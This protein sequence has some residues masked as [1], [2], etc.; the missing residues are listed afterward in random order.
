MEITLSVIAVTVILSILGFT[1]ENLFN[2]FR[3]V[4]YDVKHSGQWYRFFSYGFMHAGWFHLVINMFVLYSFG[5]MVEKAYAYYF[6][7]KYVL[8]YLL[9]YVG[10]LLLSVIPC[11]GKHKNDVFYSS[12]GASGAVSAVVFAS[13]LIAP[14][15]KIFLF[16][17]PIGIPAV[18]FGFLYIAYEYWM[19][20]R[21]KD[22]IG[23]DAHLWGAIYGLI[24]TLAIKPVIFLYFLKQLGFDVTI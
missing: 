5:E 11:F 24:F 20:R 14:T 21:A 7:A 23:H 19:S 13:I 12:V 17:I 15:Q 6:Q 4:P 2:R 9:L 10:A 8:F 1:N 22:N 16:F 3:F 18:L